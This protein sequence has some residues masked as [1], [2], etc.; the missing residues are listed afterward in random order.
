L[1]LRE[2][3]RL[4]GFASEFGARFYGRP[5]NEGR[6]TLERRSWQVPERLEFGPSDLV[7]YRAGQAIAW[8]LAGTSVKNRG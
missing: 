7:P 3:K 2:L 5:R 6:I 4:E 1:W 8:S